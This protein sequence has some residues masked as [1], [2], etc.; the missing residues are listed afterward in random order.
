MQWIN[1]S[2]SRSSSSSFDS[3]SWMANLLDPVVILTAFLLK[4]KWSLHTPTGQALNR[5]TD[6]RGDVVG[7][8]VSERLRK[9][10]R[11]PPRVPPST[12]GGPPFRRVF[13]ACRPA[14]EMTTVSQVP[15]KTRVTARST[16]GD[17]WNT[18]AV[19]AA[20]SSGRGLV[21]LRSRIYGWLQHGRRKLQLGHLHW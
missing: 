12:F 15:S 10:W 9:C 17:P 1:S 3:S 21:E 20:V 13:G 16:C 18:I 11:W 8:P 2:T 5:R 14:M 4:F 7:K 19:T 6:W